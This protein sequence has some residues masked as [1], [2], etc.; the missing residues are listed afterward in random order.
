MLTG[1]ATVHAQTLGS[2]AST[3]A[4]LAVCALCAV[5]LYRRGRAALDDRM[6]STR[7]DPLTGVLNTS[8]FD[9]AIRER[10]AAARQNGTPLAT[11]RLQLDGW[12]GLR[13][14]LDPLVADRLLYEVARRLE[15]R[16]GERLVGRSAGDEFTVLIEG[17][18][19]L[20]AVAESLHRSLNGEVVIGDERVRIAASMGVS[21]YP[22]DGETWDDLRRRA[23]FA[24]HSAKSARMGLMRSY[25]Q[26][27]E[28]RERENCVLESA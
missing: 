17:P 20:D 11:A 7:R 19:D 23:G 4:V 12:P 6:Y 15:G 2:I 9:D 3:S 16:C 24:L 8:A 10:L 13:A 25:E 28:R 21:H 22:R 1:I 27:M 14:S 5:A 26:R 18:V